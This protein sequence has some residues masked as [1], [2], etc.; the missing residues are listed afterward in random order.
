MSR[1][2]E[3]MHR[4]LERLRRGGPRD[5]EDEVHLDLDFNFDV[6]VDADV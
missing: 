1:K 2:M 3:E 4:M 5:D 6:E